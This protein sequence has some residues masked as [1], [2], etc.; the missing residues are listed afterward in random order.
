[1]SYPEED[2]D[3]FYQQLQH[4]VSQNPTDKLII[5]GDFNARVGADNTSWN[6]ALGK[7]GIGKM[8]SNGEKLLAFC[9]ENNL[10]ITNTMFKAPDC[11]KTTWMHPRSKH[12]HQIDF[13]V[14]RQRDK[15]DVLST[16]VMR[17]ANCSTDHQMLRAKFSLGLRKVYSKQGSKKPA[18][19]NTQALKDPRVRDQLENE[20]TK[21]INEIPPVQDEDVNKEWETLKNTIFSSAEKLLGKQKKK[22]QDWFDENDPEIQN[23]IANKNTAYCKLLTDKPTRAKTKAFKEACRQLQIKTREMKTKWWEE[24]AKELQCHADT[25]NMKGFYCGLREVWG[26][27][28]S[29]TSQLK[30]A[31]G[32]VTLTDEKMILKRW[33]EHFNTLLNDTGDVSLDTI[34]EIP[35]KPM[36]DW[37]DQ[38]PDLGEV[39]KAI[40]QLSDGKAPGL[41]LI[42]GEILKQGGQ[43]LKETLAKFITKLWRKTEIP[44]DWRNASMITIFKKG[45]RTDC[46]NY[47]GISLLSIAGK[48]LTRV[49]LNRLNVHLESG[50]LP[51]TQCGFRSE[52]STVDM[53]FALRQIQEKCVEQNRPLYAVFIDFTKAFDTVSRDGLWMVLAKAGCPEHFVE[54]IKQFHEG[55]TAQVNIRGNSSEPFRVNNGVKQGCVLAPSL[56]SIFLSAVLDKAYKLNNKGVYIQT[57]PGADLF[58]LNPV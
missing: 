42:P 24:K 15:T 16:T 40:G 37:L 20:I 17:G 8:N 43:L 51:E 22:N 1:M 28:V 32:S 44:S 39:E 57:R 46:G 13:I 31:D 50:L 19:L 58:N 6:E 36:A 48:V 18:K 55:M 38:E 49:I 25:N 52:R 5:L 54:M 21:A 7:F 12:W 11:K 41:D 35:Q 33:A 27:R 45:D 30:S 34:N 14:T 26:P 2:I 56:F 29:A 4:I 23:V 9:T 10:I 3:H 47:R 53:V